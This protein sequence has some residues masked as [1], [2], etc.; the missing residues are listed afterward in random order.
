MPTRPN[1]SELTAAEELK[2]N[3]LTDRQRGLLN[4]I[5]SLD[6]EF[7]YTITVTCRGAEPWKVE[8]VV[9]HRDIDLRPPKGSGEK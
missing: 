1:R 8:K 3:P 5:Q 2:L 4:L 6:P 7:R 9:E